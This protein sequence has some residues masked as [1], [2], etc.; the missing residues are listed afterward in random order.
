MF[1]N[2]NLNVISCGPYV[3]YFCSDAKKV[4][5]RPK[6]G[7]FCSIAMEQGFSDACI[8]LCMGEQPTQRIAQA[9]RAAAMEMPRPTVRKW[10]EHGYREGYSATVNDLRSHFEVKASDAAPAEAREL[11]EE[12]HAEIAAHIEERKLVNSFPI[13]LDD[14][15]LNLN[16]YEGQSAE[17]AVAEFCHVHMNDDIS[18][19]IRQLL[20]I[21]LERASSAAT[22]N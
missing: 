21:V 2:H 16:L 18:G 15:T 3:S 5:P 19:C 8:P 22:E 17:D 14:T 4:L 12:A 11:S 20:P 10:C 7:D 6:V 9:C 13:T 1:I